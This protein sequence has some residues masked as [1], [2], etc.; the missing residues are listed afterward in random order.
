LNPSCP[1]IAEAANE[2]I[3]LAHGEG[4][5]LMRELLSE[6]IVPS[7]GNP[8]LSALR[9]AAILPK[10]HGEPVFTT[11]SFVVT[12]RFFPGGDIGSLAVHGT[13]NDLAVAGAR[14]LWLSLGII[15]EEGFSLAELRQI[16]ASAAGAARLA[17]VKIVTGDTKVMPRGA[18]DGLLLNTSGVGE[19]ILPT[20]GPQALSAGDEILVTGPIAR[21]GIAVL[22]ARESL[23]FDPPVESD[24]GILYP[25]VL[26][27]LD[28]RSAVKAMR[29]A[30]RG[31]VAA[32]LHE[33][34]AACDLSIAIDE[35]AVPVT[36][37]VRGVCELLGLDP[38]HVACEGTMVLAVPSGSAE[39]AMRCL[40]TV[41]ISAAPVRIGQVLPREIA[42]V[43]VNR[44]MRRLIPLDEPAGAPLPRIC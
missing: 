12:P 19:L 29:D 7:L 9:D 34:A 43:L 20:P 5:R 30:T 8:D 4:G 35:H 38:L 3:S 18:V 33:W 25:S 44:A 16:L 14:P 40:R 39:D 15:A 17:G 37:A 24:S 32:V 22:A 28:G 1:N 31:G 10:M 36:A 13:V 27:L 42:P 21:H 26:A 6:T 23:G 2:R 41:P 11:D